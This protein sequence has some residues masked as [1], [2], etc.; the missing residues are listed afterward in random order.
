MSKNGWQF[1]F[2]IQ[3]EGVPP[4]QPPIRVV[5]EGEIGN[6]NDNMWEADSI[7]YY[8]DEAEARRIAQ[9]AVRDLFVGPTGAIPLNYVVWTE[10]VELHKDHYVGL[11]QVDL[12]VWI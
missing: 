3:G 4:D 12:G 10:T 1:T 5:V 9:E 11:N 7:V 2:S 6:V 8:G